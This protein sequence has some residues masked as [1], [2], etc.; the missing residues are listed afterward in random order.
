M[1]DDPDLF[2]YTR[3]HGQE[4]LLVACNFT[5]REQIFTLPERFHTAKVLVT[6]EKGREQIEG[7]LTLGPFAATVLYK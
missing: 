7:A 2:V 6:N 3:R 4:E 1:G 5:D